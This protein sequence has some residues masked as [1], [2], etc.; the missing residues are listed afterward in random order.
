ME[1]FMSP[2]P[3]CR[4][5][6]RLSHPTQVSKDP[7][8]SAHVRVLA[9]L[10]LDTPRP[11]PIWPLAPDL[12]NRGEH[13]LGLLTA[14][15]AYLRAALWEVSQNVPHDLDLRQIEALSSDLLSEVTGTMQLAIAALAWGRP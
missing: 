14:T 13:L 10:G 8:A 5:S 11:L 1:W 15:Y 2:H 4:S 6:Q 3:L 7:I 12:E 9:A